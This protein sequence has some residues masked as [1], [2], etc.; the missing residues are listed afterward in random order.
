MKVFILS[1]SSFPNSRFLSYPSTPSSN[2]EDL[3]HIHTILPHWR[4]STYLNRSSV[5]DF[6]ISTPSSQLQVSIIS[7]PKVSII[8]TSSSNT[9]DL[10]HIH[11]ILSHWR[12]ITSL[13]H[14]TVKVFILSTPSSPTTD[15]QPINTIIPIQRYLSYPHH[16]PYDVHHHPTPKFFP[17]QPP[18]LKIFILPIPSSPTTSLHHGPPK[19]FIK[20]RLGKLVVPAMDV[21]LPSYAWHFIHNLLFRYFLFQISQLLPTPGEAQAKAMPGRLYIHTK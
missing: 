16:P 3:Y 8:S 11:T 6:I 5:K 20:A 12:S 13:H 14:S 4:S 7:L 21:A 15:F 17:H 1:T 2:T 10:H 19:S 18:L 9:E